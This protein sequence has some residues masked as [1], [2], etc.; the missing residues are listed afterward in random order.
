MNRMTFGKYKGL[1]VTSVLKINP[2]YFGWCK[3]RYSKVYC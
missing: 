1:S 3:N 2:S